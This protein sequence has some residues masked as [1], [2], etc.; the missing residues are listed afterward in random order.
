[1]LPAPDFDG[2]ARPDCA[3]LVEGGRIVAA[4]PRADLDLPEHA[5]RIDC[6]GRLATPALVD[7]HTHLVHGGERSAEFRMRLEGR[8][9]AEIAQAGGG[10]LSTVS[11]TRALSV[12]QLV[13]A[14]LPRLDHLLAEGVGTVEIKSGYGL[15]IE[16]EL[17][18]L[19]AARELGRRRKVR[20]RT[21]WLAAH[22][23]PPEDRDNRQA[24][25][26][27]VVIAGLRQAREEGLVDAVD[28]FCEHIA[29]SVPEM[30]RVFDAAQALGL[31]VKLH[32]EQLSDLGGAAMAAR[33]G[34]LSADHLEYLGDADARVLGDAGTVA[35]LL[36]GAFYTL[37][38]TRQPPVA[39][40]RA[41]GARMALATDCNPGSSPLTSLLLTLNMGATLFGL[42]V[43]ECLIG[44]TRNAALALGLAGETGSLLPGASA[45][46][47]FWEVSDPAELVYRIG[48]NPLWRRYHEGERAP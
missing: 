4:G 6:G 18:M 46:I 26:D 10:I 42:T 45:D 5:E 3:I 36:P 37:R 20:I 41:A 44:V 31:P 9:Y 35:V 39:A 32:A 22:A 48:F 23:L 8:S 29:F 25:I 40:L 21:T 17:D 24:Y 27:D 38:E 15:A 13:E 47:A 2:P 33:R 12:E 1:M 14:A 30:E 34:A 19:R 28:G 16:P 7:C 43:P 11:A